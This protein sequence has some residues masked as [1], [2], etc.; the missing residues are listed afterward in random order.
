[1]ITHKEKILIIDDS[2]EILQFLKRFLESKGFMVYTST[3][4]V[5]GI[6]KAIEVK[7]DVIF[8]DLMMPNLDGLK[9]LN[10]KK[11]LDEIKDIPVIVISANT[12][13]RNVL[14]ALEA[15]A[16]K[17]LSKPLKNEKILEYINEVIG[18]ETETISENV[19]TEEEL[20]EFRNDLI[21]YFLNGFPERKVKITNAIRNKNLNELKSVIHEIK[22]AGGTMGYPELTEICKEIEKREFNSP[23]DW[24]FAEFKSNEIFQVINKI[25]QKFSKQIN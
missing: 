5:E 21:E 15:G 2:N 13:R 18:K 12:A 11:V 3:D 9:M 22:G 20:V 23:T 14:A 6:Q 8:L 25:K 10:V 1:M 4:G 19:L 17:V 16:D 7:P 24:V